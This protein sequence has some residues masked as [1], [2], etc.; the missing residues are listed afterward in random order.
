MRIFNIMRQTPLGSIVPFYL[1][2]TFKL[3]FFCKT[4]DKITGKHYWM[5][6]QQES[7]EDKVRQFWLVP[8]KI[9]LRTGFATRGLA[10]RYLARTRMCL[11]S[12]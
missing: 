2:L 12:C 11:C 6:H 1:I 8:R 9:S 4:N 7:V 3:D 10:L 5:M